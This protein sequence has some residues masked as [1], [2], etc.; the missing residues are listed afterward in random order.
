MN[1][2]F[3]DFRGMELKQTELCSWGP[4]Q[5]VLEVGKENDLEAFFFFFGWGGGQVGVDRMIF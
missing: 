1:L 2:T 3:Y 4:E 5:Q